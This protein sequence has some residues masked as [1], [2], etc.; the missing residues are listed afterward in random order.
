MSDFNWDAQA[1]FQ[2]LTESNRLAVESGYRFH[3]VSGLEGFSAALKNALQTKAFV[4]VSDTSEGGMDLANTPHTTRI[5]TVFFAVRHKAADEVQRNKAMANM[6]ELFRQFMTVLVQE[7]T[8]LEQDCIYL[9]DR[10]SFT[11]ISRYFY[12]G[13]AC[14]FFELRVDTFTDISFN[15]DEW[16]TLPMMH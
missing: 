6:R 1:F 3:Q 8:R 9:D 16:L 15:P 11:E 10:I 13:A 7:K 2:R 4:C 5:K 14:A 12:T